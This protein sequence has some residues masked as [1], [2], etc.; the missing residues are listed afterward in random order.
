MYRIHINNLRLIMNYREGFQLQLLSPISIF[1]YSQ[2]QGQSSLIRIP[3][4]VEI[5][6][7]CIS[8]GLRQEPYSD[9]GCFDHRGE[10]AALLASRKISL[11]EKKYQYVRQLIYH[12]S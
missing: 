8:R 10:D 11:R 7:N 5:L 4:I 3:P 2:I 6:M 9:S 1:V 12:F